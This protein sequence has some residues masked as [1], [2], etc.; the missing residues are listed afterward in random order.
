MRA[1]ID[2]ENASN[3]NVITLKLEIVEYIKDKIIRFNI[4]DIK[5]EELKLLNKAISNKYDDIDIEL[6]FI[7]DSEIPEFGPDYEFFI[8]D[9]LLV[10]IYNRDI[11]KRNN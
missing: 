6:F 3:K 10:G 8:K 7:D 9:D 5:K 2:I 1:Y 4:K 11:Y